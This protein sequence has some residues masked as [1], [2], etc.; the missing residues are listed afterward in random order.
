M[1]IQQFPQSQNR[2]EDIRLGLTHRGQLNYYNYPFEQFS[3]EKTEK[4]ELK[5]QIYRASE[6][7][8]Q[9]V[10]VF[11]ERTRHQSSNKDKI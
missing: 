3:R 2:E 1:F 5:Q 6:D 11:P 10:F 7:L 8:K 9:M 4:S